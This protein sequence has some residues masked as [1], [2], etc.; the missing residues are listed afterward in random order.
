[1]QPCRLTRPKVGLS[2]V[3]PHRLEGETMEPSVSVPMANPTSP[4]AT[5]EAEPAEE[6]L[7]PSSGFHGLRVVPP[8]HTSPMARAPQE[9]LARRTAPA[10]SSRFTTS[11]SSSRTWSL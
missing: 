6:P 4:A 11:A 10:A 3:H 5:A 7:E 2:P 9:S 1:M 8:N